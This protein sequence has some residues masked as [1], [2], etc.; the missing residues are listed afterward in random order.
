MMKFLRQRSFVIP[1]ATLITGIVVLTLVSV[2]IIH[3]GPQLQGPTIHDTRRQVDINPFYGQ[4]AVPLTNQLAKPFNGPS[5][6]STGVAL[7]STATCTAPTTDL[8]ILVIASDGNEV[9][10]PAIEQSLNYAGVPYTV[11]VSAQTPNGLS[12]STLD[13]GNCHAYYNGIILT[14][15]ELAYNTG[16]QWASGLSQAEWNLLWAYESRFHVRS[17]SWYTFP[18]VNFGFQNAATAISTNDTAYTASFTAA[19]KT[20]FPYLNTANPFTVQHA[21]TYLDAPVTDGSTAPLIADSKGNALVAVHTYSDGREILSM[22]FDSNIY[23]THSIILSY[24][25]INWVTKGLFIGQL[26]TYIASQIDDVFLDDDT[27]APTTA[28][29]TSV[30]TSTTTYRITGTDFRNM[31]TWQKVVRN[32]PEFKY[33]SLDMT[34]NGYGT[35]KDAY[36]DTTLTTAAK[37]NQNQFIW[38]NHTYDHSDLSLVDYTF[39]K[40]E[41]DQNNAVAKTL[42]LSNYTTT[43]M[44]T[45]DVS[46][47]RNA[48]FLQAAYD[49]GIR[50]LVSDTS[51]P[52]ENNPAPNESF[53]DWVNPNIQLVPRHPTNLFFNVSTPQ[54]WAAEYNCLYNKFWGRN[55]S[56]QEIINIESDTLLANMIKG[57]IDPAMYHQPN[58]RSYDGKHS[59]LGDLLD[60]TFAKY[61]ALYNVPVKSLRL[62]NI[63]KYMVNKALVRESG[64]TA[65]LTGTTVTITAKNGATIPVTGT[66]GTNKGYSLENSSWVKGETIAHI[67]LAAGQ[68][69]SFPVKVQP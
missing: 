62:D 13:D 63:G 69:F 32:N 24:G 43:A 16:T 29:G 40:S 26:N 34:F 52:G 60:A 2:S 31:V 41:L 42:R 12:E 36:T 9:D 56:Y 1:V 46:G 15:G 10:L 54:E 37:Q 38:T 64:V 55:L 5:F 7:G 27:W 4:S 51:R 39:A 3:T 23:L 48:A 35:S 8:K 33:T 58:L 17:I 49:T 25:L 57:D 11:Y 65:S 18:N 53:A 22:T 6:E 50:Y 28:C 30:D 67:P 19:G 21:Y 45:P 44:V 20:V 59:L 47:L 66:I 61:S 68:T 14:N